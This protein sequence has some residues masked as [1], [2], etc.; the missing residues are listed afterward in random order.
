MTDSAPSLSH[1]AP[2]VARIDLNRPDNANRIELSDLSALH[3]LLDKCE[4]DTSIHVLILGARGRH[5]SSGF[6]LRALLAQ[7]ASGQSGSQDGDGGFEIL[8]NRI[9]ATHLITVAAINGPVI[10]GATDLALACDVRIGSQDAYMQMPA[11]RFGLPL[12][13][14]V[15]QRYVSRLGINHAKRLVFTAQRVD[16]SEMLAI[17]FLSEIV[18][19]GDLAG[20][21]LVLAKQIADM[22]AN[23]L[24]AM[25]MALNALSVG[26]GNE[27]QIREGLRGA[28]DGPQIVQ[29]VQA[30]RSA[31]RISGAKNKF[32]REMKFEV[33]EKGQ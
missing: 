1:P 22:P 27:D 6:D 16:A 7:A 18:D 25:K 17:G 14:S 3:T 8:A 32:D 12:Y 10:G 9:E 4:A 11:A 31:S 19:S 2:H 13:S 20:R 26:L 33:E 5:F 23:P 29:R 30:V 24:V 21:C 15:L 28:F